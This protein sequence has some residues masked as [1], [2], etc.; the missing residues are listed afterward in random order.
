MVKLKSSD[1]HCDATPTPAKHTSTEEILKSMREEKEWERE[2]T[3]G[4]DFLQGTAKY[5]L[6]TQT[7]TV[8]Y[9]TLKMS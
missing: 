8:S 7:Y 3:A 5:I 2:L 4:T 1:S 9:Q 6:E